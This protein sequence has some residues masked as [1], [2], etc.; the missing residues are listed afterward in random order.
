MSLSVF[1]GNGNVEDWIVQATNKLMSK[2]YKKQLKDELKPQGDPGVLWEGQAD[3]AVG[4]LFTYLSPALATAF[5]SH[6]TP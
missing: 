3:K 2:G 4:I 5:A 6:E 1:D